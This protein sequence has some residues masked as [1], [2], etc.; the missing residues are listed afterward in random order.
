MDWTC[1]VELFEEGK[2]RGAIFD[3]REFVGLESVPKALEALG[4]RESWGKVVVRVVGEGIR[5][6]FRVD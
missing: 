6:G 2:I 5:E 1:R 4:G 3:E